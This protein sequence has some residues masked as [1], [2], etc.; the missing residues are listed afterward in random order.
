MNNFTIKILPAL[1]LLLLAAPF[2]SALPTCPVNPNS[3]FQFP[4]NLFGSA[5]TGP[6]T[7]KAESSCSSLNIASGQYYDLFASDREFQVSDNGAAVIKIEVPSQGDYITTDTC[8]DPSFT[9]NE[10]RSEV[11][12]LRIF[13]NS[14]SVVVEH[15]NERCALEIC[16]LFGTCN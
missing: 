13:E 2:A 12:Q 4:N 16:P 6:V 1:S 5:V 10:I 14:G 9:S 7:L 3:Q 8:S 15:G 11:L